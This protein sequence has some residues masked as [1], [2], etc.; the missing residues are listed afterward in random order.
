MVTVLTSTQLLANQ[1]A[2]KHPNTQVCRLSQWLINQCKT[3]YKLLSESQEHAVWELITQEP[4][5]ARLAQQ[6]WH[7]LIQWNVSLNHPAF[8]Y[9][10][11]TRQFKQWS[12]QFVQHCKQQNFL[13]VSSAIELYIADMG[14]VPEKILLAGFTEFT[15]QQQRLLTALSKSKQGCEIA[16]PPPAC[17]KASADTQKI[18]LPDPETE[19]LT[20]ARWAADYL[21]QH[22]THHIGCIIPPSTENAVFIEDAFLK[23]NLSVSIPK[24]LDKNPLMRAAL[25]KLSTITQPDTV[26]APSLWVTFFTQALKDIPVPQWETIGN[27]FSA[28]DIILP[29]ISYDDALTRLK[30]IISTT[31]SGSTDTNTHIHILS[32]IEAMGLSFD[33]LWVMGAQDSTWPPAP[34]PNPFIPISLQRELKM[35][36]ASAENNLDF[37]R[38]IT[39]QLCTQSPQIIF[40]Y[41]LTDHE[42]HLRPSPLIQNFPEVQLTLPDYVDPAKK[43]FENS[44]TE[45]ITDDQAPPAS[46]DEV[47][48]SGSALFKNQAACPFRAFA[49]HRLGAKEEPKITAGL[50]YAERGTLIHKILE[51]LWQKLHSHEKLCAYQDSELKILIHTIIQQS[52]T[53]L[54]LKPKFQKLETKR[55]EGIIWQW[56]LLE[57]KREIFTIKALE[58]KRSITLGKYPSHIRI[59]RIDELADGSHVIIDYKTGDCSES[60]WYGDRPEEPQIPL[61][62]IASEY[63]PSDAGFAQISPGNMRFKGLGSVTDWAEQIQR[64]ETVLKNLA[65]QFESGYAAV[66]PKNP[67]QTCQYCHLTSVCRVQENAG[68]D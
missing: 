61:Y 51:N 24:T 43:I 47:A 5:I 30:N 36:Y 58:Q 34:R 11:D 14:D 48:H 46:A 55:L 53:P 16:P 29:A 44:K 50:S 54:A 15:P 52:L 13:D 64:W 39:T 33:A 66:D 1:L 65:T 68:Q 4:Q 59:D 23:V 12:L 10:H 62:C 6:A 25:R 31:L 42:N 45:W 57:K 8:G 18:A 38:T 21:A 7:L 40:S 3:R 17:A 60:S 26:Q 67:P 32:P 37:Y 27:I 41:A 20:M 9:T 35:P 2:K 19:W 28:L 22:P 49:I 63:P 56:L